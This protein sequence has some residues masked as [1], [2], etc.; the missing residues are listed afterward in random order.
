MKKLLLPMIGG[1]VLLGL[2]AGAGFM[3]FL[4]IPGLSPQ[5][6]SE[7]SAAESAG[8]KEEMGPVVKLSPLV[9][10]LRDEGGRSYLKTTIVLELGGKNGVEEVNKLMSSLTDIAI[11]T[12]GD[13]RMDEL[14]PPGSKE[15]LKQEL[16]AKMNQQLPSK[17][18]RRIYFDEF[19]YE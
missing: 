12:L 14:R 18:I 16:M 8:N 2:V 6:A 4:P 13:K 11:L 17:A 19:L 15:H 10:N 3:G 5:K 7:N 9:I 1:V